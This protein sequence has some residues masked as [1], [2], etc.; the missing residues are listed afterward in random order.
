MTL[1]SILVIVVSVLFLVLERVFPGRAAF[2]D[3]CGF[4]DGAEQKL[5][6]MLMFKDVYYEGSVEPKR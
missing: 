4:P 2:A 3:R 5:G 6:A 1:P